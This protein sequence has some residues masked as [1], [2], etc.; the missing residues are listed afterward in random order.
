[1]L[2]LRRVTKGGKLLDGYV[3]DPF[4]GFASDL[5]G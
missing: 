2:I 1:Y 3:A 4:A 5:I